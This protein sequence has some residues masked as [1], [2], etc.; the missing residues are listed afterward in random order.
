MQFMQNRQKNLSL[1]KKND[2]SAV[3]KKFPSTYIEL[4]Q[5]AG[6]ELIHFSATF[7]EYWELLK[8]SEFRADFYQNEIITMSYE[9]EHHSDIITE[10]LHL[11][12]SP[13]PRKNRNF[14]MHNPNRPIYVGKVDGK[15]TVFNPDGSV[16]LQPAKHYEHSP[17][18]NA[19]TTPVLLF[20]VLSK[21]T[22]SYDLGTKLPLYKQIPTLNTILYVETKK[23]SV[24][25]MERQSKNRWLETEYTEEADFFMINDKLIYLKD[26][27][28]GIH[29]EK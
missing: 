24:I 16:V 10:L 6:N 18:M 23:P 21:S 27:Y 26:I 22:R 1:F 13:Y 15:H 14:K 29:F 3:T 4:H 7:D 28:F 19:E 20:E 25:V 5:L 17:G 12:K 2:M 8:H 9:N 11:L